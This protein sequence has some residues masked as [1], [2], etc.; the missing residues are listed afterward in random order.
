MGEM[1]I[2]I[3]DILENKFRKLAMRRFGYSK[4]SISNA[5]KEAVKNWSDMQE[6]EI[7]IKTDPI[8]SISG[9]M[10]NIKKNSVELQHEAW[11]Y[12]SK[13]YIRK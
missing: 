11:D 1:K 3:D 12:I 13:K 9:L 6:Y 10:K 8:K 2:K 7:E 5:A 4:G